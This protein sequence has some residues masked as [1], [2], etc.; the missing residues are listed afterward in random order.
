[1]RRYGAGPLHLVAHLAF[2]GLALYALLQL[3][4]IRDARY[5]VAWLIGA[6]VLHDAIL[7][8]LY[9]GADA[10]ARSALGRAVNAVRVPAGLSLVLLLAF[11]PI[12]ASKGEGAYAR[13]AGRDWS[14]YATRWVLVTAALFAL[15][16]AVYLARRVLGGSKR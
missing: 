3:F 7:W 11:F 16:G 1:M 10:L 14:G 2:G 9:S 15:S 12:I 6:V 4:G 8:P 5:A 13:V